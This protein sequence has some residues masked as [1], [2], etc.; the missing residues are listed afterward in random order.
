MI[1]Y[2]IDSHVTFNSQG[3][4][5]Y[6]RAISSEP[7]RKLIKS[8]FSDGVLP[9]PS[10]N[11]QVQA[12][13]GMTVIVNPGF[14]ICNG[15][16]KL[17][18]K[19]RTLVVQASSTSL[20]RID[21]VIL[22][23]NNNEDIRSLD[24]YILEGTPATKP[25]RP[26]LTQ[27]A[28]IWEIG[29]AD[30]FIASNTSVITNQR[31]TDTRYETA[32]CGIISSISEFDTTTL[33]Q[34]VQADLDVF[35]DV[36]E[37]QFSEWIETIQQDF[38]TWKNEQ[39]TDFSNWMSG[40]QTD[41]ENWRD[42]EKASFDAWFAALE[43]QLSGDVAA[44]LQNQIGALPSL[45]TQDKSSLVN[46]INEVAKLDEDT[47]IRNNSN[48]LSLSNKVQDTLSQLDPAENKKVLTYNEESQRW[49]G[50]DAEVT[51]N[52]IKKIYGAEDYDETKQYA[53]GDY[54]IF[55]NELYLSTSTNAAGSSPETS[56][57]KWQKIILVDTYKLAKQ[58][59]SYGVEAYNIAKRIKIEQIASKRTSST[60]KQYFFGN[61]G[62][63]YLLFCQAWLNTTKAFR[64]MNAYYIAFSPN[65]Y[66]PGT[67]T[68]TTAQTKAQ[69][70]SLGASGT[71]GV[72]LDVSRSYES[73]S[74]PARLGIGACTTACD[75]R[76]SLY[77]VM[78]STRDF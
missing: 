58:A 41:F 56:P 17:E 20:D 76:Y 11:M 30:I 19:S 15:C 51:H 21:T 1:G 74:G 77:E 8:L 57:S 67:G 52:D 18:E 28:T 49:E 12:G 61:T 26:S 63:G 45:N 27:N 44:N 13:E 72:S 23:L 60:E 22:R 29:L 31:I 35:R 55:N 9:N 10:T 68:P 75:L 69:V 25:V 43:N 6:D 7:L 42:Q 46:A 14:A 33:Y 66:D 36:S 2:P 48:Q 16:M 50:Q 71:T 64:G 54:C 24:F 47:L 3:I 73:I 4:P 39:T 38:E 34:Q 53:D 62:E 32:R 65:E 37:Q 5:S 59:N 70:L 40:E 78:G